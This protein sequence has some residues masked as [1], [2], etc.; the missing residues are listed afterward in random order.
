MLH[1]AKELFYNDDSHDWVECPLDME[2]R[3]EG[4][5]LFI[6]GTD[7]IENFLLNFDLFGHYIFHSGF[8]KMAMAIEYSPG[9]KHFIRVNKITQLIGHSS[10]GAVAAILG[11]RLNLLS[12]ALNAPRFVRG[13]LT[14]AQKAYFETSCTIIN[15]KYDV[16]SY[17]PLGFKYPSKVHYHNFLEC[18]P[19]TIHDTIVF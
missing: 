13:G 11:C 15:Q 7:S 1:S 19:R 5:R 6:R 14:N 16:V 12:M 18:D 9:F 4:N 8:Y 17:I 3:V 10:G 2:Y